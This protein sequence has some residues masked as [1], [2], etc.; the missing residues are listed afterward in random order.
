MSTGV[1][2]MFGVYELRGLLGR[3][4]MGEVH[5]A[6]DTRRGR[7][8]ALKLLSVDPGSDPTVA[9]RFRREARTVVQLSDPNIVP[10]HDFGEIDGRLYI[11]MALI[12]GRDLGDVLEAG[13][14]L[15]PD[16][17]V[18]VLGQAARA[19]DTAHRHG[20]V[21]RD[22]KPSNLLVLTDR[23]DFTYLV[24]FGIAHAVD[25]S[26]G[27]TSLTAT[28]AFIG[29]MAYIAP[30]QLGDGPVDGR[31]DVYA[32]TCVLFEMLTGRRP[33]PADRAAALMSAHLHSAPPRVTALRPDLPR[34]WDD[35]IARGMA[36]SP[37]ARPPTAGALFGLARTVPRHRTAP[38]AVAP[39]PM[40][41]TRVGP[42]GP[43]G[44]TAR[45]APVALILTAVL[46]AAA[47]VV[48]AVVVLP[49]I[50]RD[51]G[52]E[53]TTSSPP[54]AT[55]G[56]PVVASPSSGSTTTFRAF[57][58]PGWGYTLDVPEA[59]AEQQGSGDTVRFTG[60]G[61]GTTLQVS[62]RVRP[63]GE[64]RSFLADALGEATAGGGRTTYSTS[65]AT[66][67]TG[68]GLDSSGRIF[69]FHAEM[70]DAALVTATWTYAVSDKAL[71][72]TAV[73]RTS[74]SLRFG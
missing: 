8:I 71:W 56:P 35:V 60:S 70:S 32:L 69:Y 67:F 55:A 29:T 5:R 2:G 43:T 41:P 11:D 73:T 23:D 6:Y 24:D 22:V 74:T 57:R 38:T 61:T 14:P 30:E 49:T 13:G 62:A 66:S 59:L 3:G 15:A 48:A 53:R 16:R 54:A 20:L 50:G 27:G 17:A 65:D 1:A 44:S 25:G 72:D 37:A 45:R 10:V 39:P 64:A 46:V 21:H 28:G 12:E 18:H 36:K 52:A 68:S 19:L 63:A 40:P 34:E 42:P 7:E 9:E 47:L 58:D 31:A 26:N 4:G 51:G 33:F